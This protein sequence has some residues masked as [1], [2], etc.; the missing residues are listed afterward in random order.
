MFCVKWEMTKNIKFLN[1]VQV[2]AFDAKKLSLIVYFLCKQDW[3][4]F[5]QTMLKAADTE[6]L[7]RNFLAEQR[8]R[9][10][11]AVDLGSE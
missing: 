8:K 3:K 5:A 1:L 2:K 7:R 10:Y 4:L 9:L 6:S 11:L